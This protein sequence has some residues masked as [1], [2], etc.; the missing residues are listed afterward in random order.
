MTDVSR[1]PGLSRYVIQRREELHLAQSELADKAGLPRAYVNALETGRIGLPNAER[2][3]LLADVLRVRH[4]DLLIAADEVTPDEVGM[5]RADFTRH[6]ALQDRIE[7][8]DD[9][10]ARMVEVMLDAMESERVEKTAKTAKA[11]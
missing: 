11:R 7:R 10:Q 9:R 6:P 1:N 8:L 3:R 5:A 4:I 2:R